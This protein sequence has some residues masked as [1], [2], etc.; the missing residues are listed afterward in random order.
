MSGGCFNLVVVET[1]CMLAIPSQYL[2]SKY[3]G[4]AERNLSIQG[5]CFYGYNTAKS[6]RLNYPLS[7]YSSFSVNCTD[8]VHTMRRIYL[9]YIRLKQQYIVAYPIYEEVV[10]QLGK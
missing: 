2:T 6:T 3:E 10:S 8:E 7:S 9:L 4:N 5:N 1:C